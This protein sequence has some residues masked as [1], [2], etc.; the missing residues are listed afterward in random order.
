M[1]K[2]S[3]RFAVGSFAGFASL[4]FTLSMITVSA[5]AQAVGEMPSTAASPR[6]V[7]SALTQDSAEI[8]TSADGR[9]RAVRGFEGSGSFVV[10]I[11]RDRSARPVIKNGYTTQKDPAG[12]TE[13]VEVS[14]EIFDLMT[15]TFGG[16]SRPHEQWKATFQETYDG[17]VTI[18]DETKKTVGT[19]PMNC[20][21]AVIEF[22]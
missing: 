8:C 22:K 1:A 5:L 15:E 13:R 10:Q 18:L 12:R 3:A 14:F 7:P 16:V 20:Q 6:P 17:R 21:A 11:P 9:A 4:F 2:S 19:I